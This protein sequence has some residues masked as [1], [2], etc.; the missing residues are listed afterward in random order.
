MKNNEQKIIC[1]NK[2]AHHEYFIEDTYEC[3]LVLTGTEI[4]SL[5]LG[6]A[7]INDAY[8]DIKNREVYIINMHISPYDKGTLFN[9]NP[10]RERKLLLHKKEINKLLGYQTR[11][12]YTLIPLKVYL[13]KQLA[14]VEIGVAKGKKLYDKREDLKE[15][16]IKRDMS[17]NFKENNRYDE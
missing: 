14:K 8:A 5:R 6:L 9:H 12:G 3:G 16:A 1:Q 11:E 10:K 7:N 17:R 13:D 15:E 4:K 2:K